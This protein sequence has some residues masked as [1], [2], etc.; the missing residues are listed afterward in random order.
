MTLRLLLVPLVVFFL[1]VSSRPALGADKTEKG[2]SLRLLACEVTEETEKV[3]L[4]T[5]DGKSDDFDLPSSAFTAPIKVSRREVVLKAP[6]NDVPLSAIT[7]PEQGHVFAVLL[8]PKEP[9]GLSP[10]IIRLDD[11][12]F[13]PGDY[14]FINCSKETLVLHL[15]DTEAMVEAGTA[16]KSRPSGPAGG[17]F[18]KITMSTRSGSG[19]KTF[20]STRW[21]M[22]N[23]KRGFVIFTTR[24]NGRISYRAVDE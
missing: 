14:H 12:S 4:E 10:T 21:L 2:I 22:A 19:E 6:G 8:A 5:K 24:P 20:A 18:C 13:K 9:G 1:Q 3:F 16:V 23:P 7:L 17:G 11:D 15:G